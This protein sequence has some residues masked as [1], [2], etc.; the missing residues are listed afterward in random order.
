VIAGT[1]GTNGFPTAHGYTTAFALCA[2]ALAVGLVV[3][4]LI[5]R[6]R[7]EEAFAQH[8]TGDLAESVR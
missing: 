8:A 5:P 2:G 7:P 1:I 6:R 4:L 3:G